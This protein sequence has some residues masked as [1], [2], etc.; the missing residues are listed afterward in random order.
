[1]SGES[2]RRVGKGN[3]GWYFFK[4]KK[5]TKKLSLSKWLRFLNDTTKTIRK[6]S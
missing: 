2:G 4:V 6:S 1:M 5:K 3:L